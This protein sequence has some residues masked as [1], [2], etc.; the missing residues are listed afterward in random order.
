[1]IDAKTLALWFHESYERLSPNFGYETRPE[2]RQFDAESSN[3][4]LMIAV[5]AEILQ[6]L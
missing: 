2:T 5:C 4:K 3:G 6:K 1:M